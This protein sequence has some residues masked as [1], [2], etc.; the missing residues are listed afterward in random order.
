MCAF[1]EHCQNQS[2]AVFIKEFDNKT[3]YKDDSLFRDNS[4]DDV[5]CLPDH[6]DWLRILDAWHSSETN[7]IEEI[8][9]YLDRHSHPHHNQLSV[10]LCYWCRVGLHIDAYLKK[11][12]Q[13]VRESDPLFD[14]ERIVPYGSSAERTNILRP[15]EVYFKFK[16]NSFK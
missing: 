5:I 13:Q 10:V 15:D 11:L 6:A 14:V 2:T 8:E 7:V 12:M 1:D 9:L 3:K 4:M 16:A